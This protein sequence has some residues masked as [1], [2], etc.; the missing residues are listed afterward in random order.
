MYISYP[1]SI[2][3]EAIRN[4]LSFYTSL[5]VAFRVKPSIYYNFLLA[6][7]CLFSSLIKCRGSHLT[8][9]LAL[10]AGDR[11]ITQYLLLRYTILSYIKN[12]SVKLYFSGMMAP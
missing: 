3:L 4:A 2:F 12:G 6:L 5:I 10:D 8:I 7:F 11:L 1:A 9:S